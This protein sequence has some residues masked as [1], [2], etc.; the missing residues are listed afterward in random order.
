MSA[1]VEQPSN[2]GSP[3]TNARL[4]GLIQ[5][6]LPG[7]EILRTVPLGA[8]ATA[9]RTVKGAGY[10]VPLRIDVFYRGSR[11][12]LVLR[13]QAANEFGHDHRADRAREAILA[14][15]TF[16]SIPS[17][18][19]VLDAG[20]FRGDDGVVSLAGSGEFYVLTTYAEGRPYAEDLRLIAS[21]ATLSTL[22][23]HRVNALA[24]YLADLHRVR[25]DVPSYAYARA[26]RDLLGSG[27]GIFGIVD[28]YPTDAPA[29][30][31]ER[32]RRIEERCLDWRWRLRGHEGRLR[33]THGDFHPFN[34]LFRGRN[35][36]TLVDASRGC[37]GDPADDVT[38]MAINFPFF[39]LGRPGA[40]R[41]IEP[42]WRG[43]WQRY[44]ELTGDTE[45]L[46]VAAPFLAWRGLVLAN[47]KWYPEVTPQDRERILAFVEH[48]LGSPR[49][50][51]DS[52][53]RFFES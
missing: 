35:E 12:S 42:L 46:D 4:R 22:D 3:V 24:A 45:I 37:A 16:G 21:S 20:A 33:R 50:S 51:P 36:I 5:S 11:R 31:A 30:S 18:V 44:L 27:E 13:T 34:V 32:L 41:V 48:A 39:S 15:D 7:A 10:G 23:S 26:A 28:S 25:P 43:F 19:E 47:P 29:A 14:Q 9:D 49:F 2:V 17:H 6:V 53:S 1:I 52:A 40:W 8:D 38:C